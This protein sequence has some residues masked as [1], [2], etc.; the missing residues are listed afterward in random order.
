[1]CYLYGTGSVIA[2]ELKQCVICKG[3]D[4][5]LSIG[6]FDSPIGRGIHTMLYRVLCIVLICEVMVAK[7]LQ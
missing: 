5:L 2:M 4:Q 7:N 6:P 1:M 3:Q